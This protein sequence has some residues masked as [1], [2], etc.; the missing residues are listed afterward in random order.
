[1]TCQSQRVKKK[2]LTR[3]TLSSSA[4]GRKE[5]LRS[6]MNSPVPA[7]GQN[8]LCIPSLVAFIR[9][10]AG[11]RKPSWTRT[12]CSLQRI[13]V[14]ENE[15]RVRQHFF[16]TPVQ[17][18]RDLR[19]SGADLT[20]LKLW[21]TS[22]PFIERLRTE[23]LPPLRE[24]EGGRPLSVLELGSGCGLV[25]LAV[26]ALGNHVLLTDPALDVNL[27]EDECGN[28]LLRL[29]DN[30]ELNRPVHAG[31]ARTA[32][33]VW[34][35]ERDMAAVEEELDICRAW[36]G[37]EEGPSPD[38]ILGCDLLYNPDSYSALCETMQRFSC[39]GAPVLL[40]YP[41]RLPGEK[42]FFEM[43]RRHFHVDAG[44]LLTGHQ[45]LLAH[46]RRRI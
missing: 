16:D 10:F 13:Q 8:P 3:Q 30:V 42:R 32:K 26:A 45:Q 23:V 25:G 1:M 35:D 27:S 9:C 22:R 39:D 2:T 31:R 43:V 18:P 36:R 6:T 37:G 44:P 41:P 24:R 11:R 14:G 40:A 34:G 17:Q 20:G 15:L 38:L 29:Q 33:L 21:P 7:L 4:A 28:T 12:A 5:R 46:C 19:R